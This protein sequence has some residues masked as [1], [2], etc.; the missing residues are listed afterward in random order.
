[1]KQNINS[2]WRT[3]GAWIGCV[4]S[5]IVITGCSS[6]PVEN[7]PSKAAA[8]S[9]PAPQAPDESWP[10]DAYVQIGMPDPGRRWTAADFGNC[11]DI[12][13]GVDRTNRTALPRSESLKSGAVFARLINPTNTL[14]LGEQFLPP[15]ERGR[16]FIT[17]LNR[18]SAF[19][20]IYR[21]DTRGPV[22]L[23]EMMELNH[24]FLRMLGSAV[25]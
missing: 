10:A 3:I 23:R 8:I 4:G 13:N 9:T 17:I 1:M 6:T 12:L 7:T 5:L 11:R 14:L 21:F 18:Y 25:E 22:L 16:E 20:D 24:A 19:R 2:F 15:E